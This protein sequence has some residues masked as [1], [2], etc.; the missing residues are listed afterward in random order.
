VKPFISIITI[1]YQNSK[2]LEKTI[3]SVISQTNRQFEYIIV[4]GA[5]SDG[6]LDVIKKYR[7]YLASWVSEDDNGIYHAM[8]KG[9]QRAKGEYCIFLN[10]GDFLT[11]NTILADA[12]KYIQDLS[13]DIIYGDLHAYDE[14]NSWVSV[15]PEPISLYYFQHSFIPHPSTFIKRNLLEKLGG[16]YEHYSIVSDWA[17]FIRALL[18]NG[19][20]KHID[21][22]V[23]SFYMNGLSSNGEKS[24]KEKELLFDNEFKF[25]A[26]DFK[27]FERLRHFDTSV[28]TKV[29]LFISKIKMRFFG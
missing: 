13:A 10:S 21:I 15:F 24:T 26:E 5:S 29:A 7:N 4:D 18:N 23:T 22:T 20:F 3:L 17:F 16:F 27:N 14:S 25:L 28:I 9:W 8:N 6:S 19:T 2:E 11:S 12:I 1:N